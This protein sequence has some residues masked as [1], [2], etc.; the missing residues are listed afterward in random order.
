LDFG[1]YASHNPKI[2]NKIPNGSWVILTVKGDENFNLQS[3]QLVK[4]TRARKIVEAH[5]SGKTWKIL[6]PINA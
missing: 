1:T 5:K 2:Y 3:R 6:S 4:V